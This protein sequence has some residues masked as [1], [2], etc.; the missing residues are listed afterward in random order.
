LVN[1]LRDIDEDARSGRLYVPAEMLREAGLD[2]HAEIKLL[3]AAP[4]FAAVRAALAAQARAAFA[5]ADALGA[6]TG[7]TRIFA[8]RLIA[9]TYRGLLA[10][11]E[12]APVGA[13][14]AGLGERIA[15]VAA[16]LRA[17]PAR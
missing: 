12:R 13:P 10:R 1:I 8:V 7:A 3:L 14:R 2:P 15:V 6:G 17:P 9:G 16:A 11:L 4:G 5:H